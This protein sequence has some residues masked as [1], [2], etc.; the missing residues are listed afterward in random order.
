MC[1]Q[2]KYSQ[3]KG[4]IRPGVAICFEAISKQLYGYVAFWGIPLP[5]VAPKLPAPRKFHDTITGPG[6]RCIA[7]R[8]FTGE[9]DLA[10]Y[11]SNWD[12]TRV[13]I[14]SRRCAYC[15]RTYQM[16]PCI[17]D[18]WH[19]FFVCTLYSGLRR[20]LPF[21]ARDVLVEGHEIQGDGC[22][23]RNLVS[24]LRAVLSAPRPESVVD[25]LVRAMRHRRDFR[26]RI[27]VRR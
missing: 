20:A 17:E 26:R 25:F 23:D 14:P 22:T 16:Q 11:S 8:F 27:G 1:I 18:E 24:L 12:L 7:A 2:Y 21:A 3:H 9:L 10:A 6:R 19:V 15:Y 13:Y 4:V 5:L